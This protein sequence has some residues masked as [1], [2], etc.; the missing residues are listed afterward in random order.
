LSQGDRLLMV[1][2]M[3]KIRH[4]T[5]HCGHLRHSSQFYQL[6][7]LEVSLDT[8]YHTFVKPQDIDQ[9]LIGNSLACIAPTPLVN[10]EEER[11]MLLVHLVEWHHDNLLELQPG[12]A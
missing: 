3:R 10:L 12:P 11:K 1:L 6:H 5:T 2:P 4:R 8:F 7:P 9:Y